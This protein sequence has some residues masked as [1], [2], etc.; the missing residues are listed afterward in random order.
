M[1]G[2]LG[3]RFAAWKP[4]FNWGWVFTVSMKTETTSCCSMCST[5]WVMISSLNK[6]KH[7]TYDL[8]TQKLRSEQKGMKSERIGRAKGKQDQIERKPKKVDI[9]SIFSF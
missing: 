6:A 8:K 2:Y 9:S 5:V 7:S 4:E 3:G 1:R